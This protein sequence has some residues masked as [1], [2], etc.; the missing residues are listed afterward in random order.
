MR[1]DQD[2][3]GATSGQIA[4]E[5]CDF[6]TTLSIKRSSRLIS[7]NQAR[8]TDQGPRDRHTLALA[9]REFRRCCGEVIGQADGLQGR[10][11]PLLAI[12]FAAGGM[13]LKGHR[14]VLR[15]V[16]K[17]EQ[18]VVLENKSDAPS[19]GD[20]VAVT[21]PA[22]LLAED[23]TSAR[24][25][26]SHR[27]DKRQQGGLA[28]SRWAREEYYFTWFYGQLQIC[29]DASPKH[30]LTVCVQTDPEPQL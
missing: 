2:S 24:L 4:Q 5:M 22:Q 27:T 20:P 9:P 19:D 18:P 10:D 8:I 23:R 17:I 26:S 1:D 3:R 30:A 14:H 16:Q 11:C 25:D 29:E 12:T 28:A 6:C 21:G 7:K 13:D 15:R